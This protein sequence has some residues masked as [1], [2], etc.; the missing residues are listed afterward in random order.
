MDYPMNSLS[1]YYKNRQKT[2]IYIVYVAFMSVVTIVY[3]SD[4]RTH[5]LDAHDDQTFADN[6][7]INADFSYFFSPGKSQT[8]GRPIAELFKF[9]LFTAFGN[10]PV[11]FHLATVALHLLASLLLALLY[12]RIHNVLPLAL[13]GAL[14]FLIGV[15][16]FQAIHH[17][18]ALDYPLAL[19]LIILAA[20]SFD[21]YLSE[22]AP[23]AL[24]AYAALLVLA[25]AAHASALFLIPFCLYWA[26]QRDLA[27]RGSWLWALLATAIML[28]VTLIITAHTTTTWAAI[29]N[30]MGQGLFDAIVDMGELYLWFAGRLLT[31]AH[32]LPIKIYALESWEIYP[33]FLAV[34]ALAWLAIFHRSSTGLWGA[35]TLLSLSPFA[36]MTRDVIFIHPAGTS[37]YLYIA[38]CRLCAARGLGTAGI[39]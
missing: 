14:L 39:R 2:L 30:R 7:H 17:I 19:I 10:S 9:A 28:P 24:L 38:Q 13:L 33:G 8:S 12:Y 32:W 11:F 15:S 37:R 23:L 1:P 34:T 5:Q 16:H 18:S 26:H 6:L 27:L 22:R 36:L 21:R 29:E 31:T 25:S 3:F 35:W 20:L 4:L